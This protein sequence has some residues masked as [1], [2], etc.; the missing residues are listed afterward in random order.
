MGLRNGT[1]VAVLYG[2]AGYLGMGSL[3]EALDG[4]GNVTFPQ[5]YAPYEGE[6]ERFFRARFKHKV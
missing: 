5:F 4:S 6:P 1:V 2:R 3:N